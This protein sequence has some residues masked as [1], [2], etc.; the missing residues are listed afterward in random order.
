M[1]YGSVTQVGGENSFHRDS[2]TSIKDSDI[3]HCPSML[4]IFKYLGLE[5]KLLKLHRACDIDKHKCSGFIFAQLYSILINEYKDTL[6]VWNLPNVNEE[7]WD[8]YKI[9]FPKQKP[10]PE[11]R[12]LKKAG[13]LLNTKLKELSLNLKAFHAKNQKP[14]SKKE[15]SNSLKEEV[16]S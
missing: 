9:F 13:D 11:Q 15:S 7:M 8:N 12:L 14:K 16:G 6:D 3:Y 4:K 10:L 5:K 1:G 2:T